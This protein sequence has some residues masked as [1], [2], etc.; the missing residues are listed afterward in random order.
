MTATPLVSVI[1]PAY[2][3]QAT[4]AQALDSVLAQTYGPIEVI[5]ADDGSTDGTPDILRAYADQVRSV[6]QANGRLPKARNAGLALA[7][8]EYVAL[9][10]ADDLCRPERIEVQV[11]VMQAHPEAVLCSSDFTSFDE[12]GVVATSRAR[13]YYSMI[14]EAGGFAALYPRASRVEA[15]I[16]GRAQPV[17]IRL[18]N[19]YRNLAFGNFVHPPTVLARR[20]ALNAAGGWDEQQ[21]Y[22]GDWECLVR[23][24]RQGEFAHIERPLLDYRLSGS[25]N[26]STVRNEGQLALSV[27]STAERIWRRDP[28]LMRAEHE[29]MERKRR[30]F[31]LDAAHGLAERHKLASAQMLAQ[32]IRHGGMGST[33]ARAF[34]RLVLPQGVVHRLRRMR[35]R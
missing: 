1:I 27:V 2:N 9:M 3:A 21:R 6:R 11:R 32:A 10:D 15:R 22:N 26:S 35:S 28:E 24:S 17:D 29:R 16:D 19:V 18:G 25:Q 33:A 7:Q 30:E 23:V 4:L 8:G 31:C 13:R 12:Q 14:D 20:S 34:V 5:V